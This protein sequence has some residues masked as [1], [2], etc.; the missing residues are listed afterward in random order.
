ML[1]RA[2]APPGLESLSLPHE[3]RLEGAQEISIREVESAISRLQPNKAPGLDKIPGDL[4][5]SEPKIWAPYLC[6]LFNAI[7]MGT[8][9]PKT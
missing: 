6:V 2:L 1:N 3:Y 9:P 7:L 4:F 8:S 5:G